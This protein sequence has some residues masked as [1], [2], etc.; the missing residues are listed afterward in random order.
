M[1]AKDFGPI[2]SDYA[3]FMAHAT[4][5]ENDAAQYV[6]ELRTFDAGRDRIRLLDFGCGSGDF[7]HRLLN[8]LRWSPQVLDLTLME[9]VPQHR[10]RARLRLAEFS[11]RPVRVLERLDDAPEERFDL[12]ISNHVLYYV[13][14][15]EGTLAQLAARLDSGGRLLLA[16]AG[17]T[18]PLMELWQTGFELL[19]RAPP[20]HGAEDVA[21]A[22]Y[23]R[24]RDFRTARVPYSLRFPNRNEHRLSILRF[25]F[26][27]HLRQMPMPA[28]LAEFDRFVR[29]E[30]I[31]IEADCLH[32]VVPATP[33]SPPA[34]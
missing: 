24:Q 8:A 26:G 19:G 20:Y 27:E 13:D 33:L 1:A 7:S 29:G 10:E 3:F 18:N 17:W 30:L 21:A 12:I 28:L 6:R 32:F 15:L 22:L 34:T 9:P 23:R 5:A 31:V 14:D 25:L 4:E 11:A 2:E 16:I